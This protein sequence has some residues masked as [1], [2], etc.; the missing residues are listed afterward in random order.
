MA[1]LG[2]DCQPICELRRLAVRADS[3]YA[4]QVGFLLGEML[5]DHPRLGLHVVRE[6][7]RFAVRPGLA[8]R[9]RYY[10]VVFLNQLQLSHNP[11]FGVTLSPVL[12]CSM[13]GPPVHD[14]VPV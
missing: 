10:A 1:V 3:T 12:R 7:E 8:H 2:S 14:V 13:R 6:V 11:A 9:A 4:W 5:Q